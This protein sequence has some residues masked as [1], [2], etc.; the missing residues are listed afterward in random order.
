MW[1]CARKRL[2]DI[3][4]QAV[5]DYHKCIVRCIEPAEHPV[6]LLDCGCDDGAWTIELGKGIGVLSP[7]AL[8][9]QTRSK[10]RRVSHTESQKNRRQ[11]IAVG[12]TNKAVCCLR[13]GP[14]AVGHRA[15]WVYRT[16]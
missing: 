11:R 13:G 14:E 16:E 12:M 1:E 2:H 10:A 15:G 6:S 4:E 5:G 7:A 9:E 8:A 3:R